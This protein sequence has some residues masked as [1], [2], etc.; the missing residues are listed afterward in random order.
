MLTR[1]TLIAAG[2]ATAVAPA[3]VSRSRAAT[4]ANSIVIGKGID[5]IVALDPAQA[6]EATSIEVGVNIYRKIVSPDLGNL[7]KIAPDLAEAWEVSSDGKVFTFHLTKDARFPSGK[8]MT[9]ADAEFSLHRA[10]TL[11]LTP[12]FIL[13]QFGFTKDNVAQ[14]IRA[15]D[16]QT[17]VLELPKPAATSYVLYC[18][19]ANV[20]SVVEKATVLANQVKNDLGNEWLNSHSAGNGPYQL[21]AFQAVDH[22]ILDSNPHSGIQVATKRFL[23]RHV[24]EPSAQLLLVQRG[25]IDI[26]RDLTSDQLRSSAGDA[27][28][29]R[30]ASPTTN[31]LYI[32]ANQ[33]FA[34]FAKAEV[35]Q[36]L[37]WAID[38]QGIQANI[39]PDSYLVNQSFLPSMILGAVTTM[40]F[41][42]DPDKAK[43]LLA[44]AG[45]ADGFAVTLDHFSEPPFVDIA[46]AIQAN[47]A[48]VGIRASLAAGTRKQ[49][50]TKMRARQHQLLM[51]QWFPDYFDPNSNAQAFNANPDDSDDSPL[52]IIAWRCHF[53]DQQL[54]Q[55]VAQAA[56]ELDTEKRVEIYHQMQQQ[57]WERSPIA[58][59]LQQN[60]VALARKNV[61]DFGLGA[62]ADF[63][64]YAKTRKS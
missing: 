7:T 44:Q 30:F 62:Q 4:P 29:H 24:K 36:A 28:L 58:F 10:I 8:P 34:P 43:A 33:G 23:I 14:L 16:P 18:L 41:K 20:G 39:V 48:Q 21:T 57:A 64:R 61:V 63:I 27:N 17:L 31:Q 3:T 53:H 2:A 47:L 12:G 35:R 52:K 1:R 55:E 51:S 45:F 40:P 54:T 56:A 46:T 49:V 11:N 50:Y 42:H 13:T 26:A 59:M 32:A 5:D 38:Y 60:D 19:S 9:S 6:Y 37:K 25:D 15:T 22:I